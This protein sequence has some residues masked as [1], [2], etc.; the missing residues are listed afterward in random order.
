MVRT[1]K[2]ILLLSVALAVFCNSSA[3]S[4]DR[5]I[6]IF[7]Y[8]Q[9]TAQHQRLSF[10]DIEASSQ[11]FLVQQLNI[12]FQ[13]ELSGQWTSLVDIELI[14]SFSSQRQ[15]GALN[16]EEAWVRY[17]MNKHF[18]LK[19]GLQIPIFNNLNEI[20]NRTPLLPYILRPLVYENSL[21][22]IVPVEEFYPPRAYVQTYGFIPIGGLKFDYALYAGNSPNINSDI[23]KGQTG[24]DTTNSYLG[25]GRVGIRY[26]EIKT[27]LSA[28]YDEISLTPGMESFLNVPYSRLEKLPRVRLGGDLSYTFRNL[29]FEGEIILVYYDEEVPALDMEAS[30]YYGTLG[31]HFWDR[32]FV[33]LSYWYVNTQYPLVYEGDGD[34]PMVVNHD[35]KFFVPGGGASYRLNDRITF[36]I[37]Y[38][39]IREEHS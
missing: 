33:Y 5:P 38:A 4:K 6:K 28:T 2:P 16:L 12:F 15:W 17:R 10:F 35:R 32:L 3:R 24:I 1:I 9:N 39:P 19:L 37:Q 8:F 23:E 20:K 7:G 29:Y 31:Y 30:F 25:G 11:T 36:K 21:S 18:S 22:E 13:K 14:N 34:S 26:R 27:G